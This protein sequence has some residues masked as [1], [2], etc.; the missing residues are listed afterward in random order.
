MSKQNIEKLSL[1]NLIHEDWVAH[2][3]DWTRPWSRAV[4][5]LQVK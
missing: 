4:A 5:Y 1:W 3:R 2:T